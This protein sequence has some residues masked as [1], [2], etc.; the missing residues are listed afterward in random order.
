MAQDRRDFGGE[1][2][3][4]LPY[5]VEQR[6]LAEAVARQE[7]LARLAV[8][9]RE[10]EHPVQPVDESPAPFLEAVDENFGVRM[11]A[12]ED[13]AAALQFGAKGAVVVD[14]SVENDPHRGILVPHGL[15]AA[16]RIDHGEASVAEKHGMVGVDE[17]A[18]PIRSPMG[19]GIRHG[20]QVVDRPPTDETCD[21]AHRSGRPGDEGSRRRQRRD[22]AGP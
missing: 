19:E 2:E 11:I 17:M 8:E 14:H 1:D 9:D 7:E 22:R 3:R 13:M 10:G 6:L 4:I 18:H 15:E 20:A 12:E 21:P 16:L 5:G